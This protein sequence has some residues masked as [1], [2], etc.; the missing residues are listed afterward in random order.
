MHNSSL[1]TSHSVQNLVF[2]FDEHITFSDQITSVSK[3]CCQL[4]CIRPYLN[5]KTACTIA[6]S[7]IHSKLWVLITVIPST[8]N[9]LS[10]NYPVSCR[11]RTLLLVL[12][13]KL[14]SPA[15]S[16]P[17][18]D[19]STGSE[20]LNASNPS[21]S[22]L[23][24][25]FSQLPNLHAFITSSI[26]RLRSTRFSSV[27][28]LLPTVIILSKNNWS[29]LSLFAPRGARVPHFPLFSP[30]SIRLLIFWS[31]LL[32]LFSFSHSLYLFSSFVHPFPFYQNSPTPF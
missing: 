28:T 24:T 12:Y 31:F 27:V 6:T 30:L 16:L 10:L 3:A 1:D 15:I 7:I 20:S 29:L 18:Y 14:F 9:S 22:H 23:P 8:V 32:F 21:S 17:S 13:A 26:Q 25:K 11:Y 4:H 5:L 19:L 2:I